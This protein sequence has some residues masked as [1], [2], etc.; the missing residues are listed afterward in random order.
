[1]KKYFVFSDVHGFYDILKNALDKAGFDKD[2]P[3]HII[4][5]CGD[6]MDRGRQPRECVEFV[7]SLPADR[8]IL[9][10]GNH[11]DLLDKLLIYQ[12]PLPHDISNGTLCTV[13]DFV[14]KHQLNEN[15]EVS[16]GV[17]IADM[18]DMRSDPL[19]QSY[20]EAL[21][22]YAEVGKNVFVHGWLPNLNYADATLREWK[23]AMWYNGMEC[24]SEDKAKFD[25]KTIFCG[26]WNTSWG[27]SNLHHLGT[28]WGED[29][30]TYACFDTFIDEGIVAL[31]ACTAFSRQVNVYT[32]EE[33]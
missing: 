11:E 10:M 16:M 19:Y 27:H 2:N 26:H 30:D 17:L 20:C 4:I 5:S 13:L 31:D 6:L 21:V 24:W 29:P 3:D 22:P 18:L 7:M 9:V 15:N 8:R 28:E 25:G 32:F 14:G 23:E 33:E 12:S 1:M